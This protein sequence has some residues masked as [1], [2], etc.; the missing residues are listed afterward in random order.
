MT[1]EGSMHPRTIFLREHTMSDNPFD[2]PTEITPEDDNQAAD[3][4][5]GQ[6]AYNMPATP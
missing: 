6:V 4:S 2:P 5:A 1:V 3:L